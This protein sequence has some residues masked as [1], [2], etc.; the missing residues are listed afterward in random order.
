M[1]ETSF[2]VYG[3][4]FRLMRYMGVF[5]FRIEYPGTKLGVHKSGIWKWFY[6]INF[7]AIIFGCSFQACQLALAM[8]YSKKPLDVVMQL[9]WM[10]V[11]CVPLS[12]MMGFI[13]QEE[14][15]IMSLNLW[16]NLE[17]S[18][19]GSSLRNLPN[20]QTN[21]PLPSMS[22]CHAAQNRLFRKQMFLYTVLGIA[23][24]VAI[25][26]HILQVPRFP[27]YLYS[28]TMGEDET[29]MYAACAYHMWLAFIIFSH[30]FCLEVI[31]I[32]TSESLCHC[33]ETVSF[34]GAV[35]MANNQCDLPHLNE[36]LIKNWAAF[37]SKTKDGVAN[38]GTDT[39]VISKAASAVSKKKSYDD[40]SYYLAHVVQNVVDIQY[41]LDRYKDI[42]A[43]TD[44]LNNAFG[45][46]IFHHQSVY[47]ALMCTLFYTPIRHLKII[48][49]DGCLLLAVVA[50]YY[51]IRLFQFYPS[52]GKLNNQSFLFVDSWMEGLR[53]IPKGK[54]AYEFYM[55]KLESCRK[56]SIDCGGFYIMQKGTVLTFI[57]IVTTHVIV[58]LQLY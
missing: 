16:A 52:M 23:A 8:S 33:L 37:D 47:M 7:I 42:E 49:L 53:H 21:G 9:C 3:T 30:I 45:P 44:G 36:V 40:E 2:G 34:R 4:Y 27:G 56:L 51:L 43:A 1:D 32:M 50:A 5:P 12:N 29:V 28:V 26:M 54:Y 41:A 13:K 48:P 19:I 55:H 6:Y 20:I 39:G 25:S 15:I 46:M 18:V 11:L 31:M 24:V 22:A 58:I 10:F 57:S 35:V 38:G 17:R 14:K